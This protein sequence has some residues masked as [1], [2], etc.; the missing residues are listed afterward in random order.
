MKKVKVFIP[1]SSTLNTGDAAILLSTINSIKKAFAN[2]CEIIVASY[3][4][5]IAKKHYPEV[6]YM[7]F[8]GSFKDKI[9]KKGKTRIPRNYFILFFQLIFG[10]IPKILLTNFELQMLN[11]IKKADIILAPGGGY[12]TDS[13]YIQF[14]LAL[15]NYVISKGKK[16]YFYAQSIGPFWK[17]TTC[18]F[19]KSIF[20]KTDFIILRDSESVK[21]LK[22]LLVRIPKQCVLSVDEA[23]LLC[24]INQ[25]TRVESKKIGISVRD[26]NFS[27]TKK[28]YKKSINNYKNNLKNI[29]EFLIKEYNYSITFISTCQGRG[30][31]K[32]DSV[33]ALKIWNI[34]DEK[35]KKNITVN[36][37]FHRPEEL[38]ELFCEFDLFIGTRMHSII[39]NFLNLTPC[40]G[41][42]YEFK[43]K[44]LF[45]RITLG[46]YIFDMYSGNYDLF[47]SK[48]IKLI[49]NKSRIRQK[50]KVEI[51][52]LQKLARKNIESIKNDYFKNKKC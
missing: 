15:F 2:N 13:Y 48:V 50:L 41:I 36:C 45:N 51:P 37:E 28:S 33:L 35:Y 3:Q 5:K 21:N 25:E 27:N 32:D 14:H 12:L 52:K 34:V 40:L 7:D 39:L 16:L 20:L 19:L 11:S 9:F 23:F 38:V 26:W 22:K 44:E 42:V 29:C 43:T 46:D 8:K 18:R 49:E 30:E 6:N 1:F 17:K 47:K 4:A 10:F 31:Y 24:S